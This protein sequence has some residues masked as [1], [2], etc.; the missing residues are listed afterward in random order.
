[1]TAVDYVKEIRAAILPC[2]Y[3]HMLYCFTC[4]EVVAQWRWSSGG[5]AWCQDGN[6]AAPCWSKQ[7]QTLHHSLVGGMPTTTWGGGEG[8]AEEEGEKHRGNC[9]EQNWSECDVCFSGSDWL[10]LWLT[11]SRGRSSQTCKWPWGWEAPPVH[12]WRSASSA[13]Q[14]AA[15]GAGSFLPITDGLLLFSQGLQWL[16]DLNHYIKYKNPWSEI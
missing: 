16:V 13:S 11:D 4:Q 9:G 1:M 12:L 8:K 2:L 6:P 7:L 3:L 5:A 10:R 14:H 15:G